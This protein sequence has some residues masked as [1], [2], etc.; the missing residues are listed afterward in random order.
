M[1]RRV[2]AGVLIL[3]LV[4]LTVLEAIG[5][6]DFDAYASH[7]IAALAGLDANDNFQIE[8]AQPLW[9][10]PPASNIGSDQDLLPLRLE[11]APTLSIER[12]KP[13]KFNCSFL[14]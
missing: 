4:S 8:T 14:I 2:V 3:F 11:N 6:D 9:I 13:Y 12:F 7:P 1:F 10:Q 5:D